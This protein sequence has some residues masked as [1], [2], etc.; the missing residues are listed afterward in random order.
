MVINLLKRKSL[1]VFA[2][3]SNIKV[4]GVL[5]F[6]FLEESI[7]ALK[8]MFDHTRMVEFLK[9]RKHALVL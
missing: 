4:N 6:H 5:F 9:I 3:Q 2:F 1:T 7:S 8:H